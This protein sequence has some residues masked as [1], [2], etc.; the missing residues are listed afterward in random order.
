VVLEVNADL[1][2]VKK[3]KLVGGGKLK[4]CKKMEFGNVVCTWF[5]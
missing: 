1:Q 3:L 5:E 2:V 4:I